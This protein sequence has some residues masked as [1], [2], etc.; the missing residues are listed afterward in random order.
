M[1]IFKIQILQNHVQPWHIYDHLYSSPIR[2]RAKGVW[3][4]VFYNTLCNTGIFR[5]QGIFRILSNVCDGKFYS[6]PCVTPAYLE[7]WKIQN[8]RHSQNTAKHISRNILFKTF[9]NPDIFRNLVYSG[10]WYILK[11][12]HI[13]NPAKCPRWSILHKL[14]AYS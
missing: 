9:C 11:S 2:M 6:Q 4:A 12:K 7:P 5:T 8:P 3:Q 10:L 14:F 13:Q 1:R